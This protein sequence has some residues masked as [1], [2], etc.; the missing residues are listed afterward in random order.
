MI[1]QWIEY[2]KSLDIWQW[3][4]LWLLFSNGMQGFTIINLLEKLLKSKK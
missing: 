1:E 2:I 4:V 3:V